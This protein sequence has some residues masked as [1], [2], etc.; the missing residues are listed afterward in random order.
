MY[1]SIET[2]LANFGFTST[3]FFN[4]ARKKILFYQLTASDKL[5]DQYLSTNFKM[6]LRGACLYLLLNCKFY[7]DKDNT[8]VIKFISTKADSL[9]SL[10]T[11]G[12]RQVKGSPILS[13]AF[14]RVIKN[15]IIKEKEV[16]KNGFRVL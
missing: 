8:I 6:T 13:T 14:G 11:Y 1:F 16:T 4:V 9:A 15:H 2:N 12:N 7:K 3:K 10:I 5:L